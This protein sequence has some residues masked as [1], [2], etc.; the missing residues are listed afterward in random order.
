M[1]FRSVILRHDP[2]E[3]HPYYRTYACRD[4][5]NMVNAPAAVY[6]NV[7][8]DVMRHAAANSIIHNSPVWFACDVH[9]DYNQEYSLLS[10]EAYDYGDLMDT[11]FEMTKAQMLD[12][13]YS[14]P[15]HAMLI[16]G[17]D[18]DID[19]SDGKIEKDTQINRW[20]V[21]NS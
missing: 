9:K 14:Y 2:R 11:S 1:L 19:V 15:T 20:R 18:S 12:T 7:P 21:E 16:V 5:T 8:I 17:L 6:F 4:V 13:Y 10:T 3:R